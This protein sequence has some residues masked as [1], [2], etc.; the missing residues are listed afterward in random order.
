MASVIPGIDCPDPILPDDAQGIDRLAIDDATARIVVTF[1]RRIGTGHDDLLR[2]TSYALTGG[3]RIFPH[4]RG[5]QRF[6][7]PDTPF[8]L[9]DRRVA[10]QLD[11]IGD[12]SIYTLTV[13]AAGV[14]PFFASRRLRFRLGCDD[15]FDCREPVPSPEPEP[16]LPVAIDYLAKDYVSFRQALIDF[17]PTRMPG[18]TERSEADVGMM[19]VELFAHTADELSYRQD[20]VAQEAFLATALERRS[21]AGHLALIGYRLDEG[22]AAWTWLQFNA[23][24][25]TTLSPERRLQ[26]SAR[27]LR[28]DEP[29]IIFETMT[30]ASLDPD[31]NELHAYDWGNHG[32]CLPAD[33]PG[34]AIRGRHERLTPGGW[35]LLEDPDPESERRDIVRITDVEFI[36]ATART[37]DLTA[38]R[39]SPETPLR[40]EHCITDASLVLRGNLV[41]AT[42]GETVSDPIRDLSSDE[43]AAAQREA[44]RLARRGRPAPRLRVRLTHGPLAHIDR[45]TLDLADAPASTEPPD[46]LED[47]PSSGSTLELEVA[48]DAWRQ[49]PTLLGRGPQDR[50]FRVEVDDTGEATVVFGDGRLGAAPN[51]ADPIEAR[52]RVGGGVV[53]NVG[54]DVLTVPI[55]ASP[56]ELGWL[57]PDHPVR[58]P[59]PAVGGRDRET[60]DHA[61][62]T[63]PASFLAP[64]V[65]VTVADYQAAATSLVVHGDAPIQRARATFRWTG[66]WLTVTVAVDRRGSDVVDAAL[67]RALIAHLDRRRLAGY[68]LELVPAVYVPIDLVVEFCT[69][70]GFRAA[71]VEESLLHAL[72][73]GVLPDG[74]RGLFHPDELSFGDRLFV[75][76]IDAAIMRVPGVASA[77]IVRLARS[78]APRA[79]DETAANL[80]QGYLQVAD[81][82]IARLDNDRNF[83]ENGTLRLVAKGAA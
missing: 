18:W 62:R 83:P 47:G 73:S 24:Q 67:R 54:A 53:G 46:E 56:G 16:E 11:T 31:L 61:R 48:G 17:I 33:A 39:W 49:Q 13:S 59:L 51:V 2:P 37:P 55:P 69:A 57:D 28:D 35:L 77:E 1:A 30:G 5:V 19:L 12:F 32:C 75:S 8:D 63:G 45:S 74:T 64:I 50:V 60:R 81:D 52:Y 40:H 25:L 82:Q 14:D 41:L 76:R 6:D 79:A 3:R 65:A 29:E 78:H 27:R 43:A 44:A 20:R 80:R 7:P 71:D 72:G 21:V 22:A 34:L 36:A 38:I 58:N 23:T 68:D 66:S 9:V 26:V 10:L 70:D 15:P 4:V 42:H